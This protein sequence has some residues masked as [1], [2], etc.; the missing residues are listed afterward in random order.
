M[1]KKMSA[2]LA[3]A[4]LATPLAAL[5]ENRDQMTSSQKNW[6]QIRAELNASVTKVTEDV[7]MT[8][9][10]IGN[11]LNGEFGGAARVTN[12]QFNAAP[13]TSNLNVEA[14]DALGSLTATAAAIGNTATIKVDEKATGVPS[15]MGSTLVNDQTFI[16]LA[17]A[18]ARLRASDITGGA[19]G[20]GVTATAAAIGNSS[21]VDVTGSVNATN[22]QRFWGDARS[23]LDAKVQTVNGDVAL[24]SAAIANTATYDVRDAGKFSLAN[25]Q[26]TN[27]DPTATSSVSLRDVTGDVTTTT[28][29]I[30]N[31]LNVSTLPAG[32]KMN[33]TSTQMNG[34]LVVANSNLSVGSVT[35]SLSATA[36]A[37]GNTATVSNLPKF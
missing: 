5:A 32:A 15:A 3:I 27:V 23:N 12:S 1:S 2:L 19:D 33:V 22:V 26:I 7:T 35:G 31:S 29:A 11:S 21:S 16:G 37:I 28:A 36:A 10:A 9:A 17:T 25:Y 20:K 6:A 14:K 4:A 34:A 18:N 8:S 30:S 13:I 24:T